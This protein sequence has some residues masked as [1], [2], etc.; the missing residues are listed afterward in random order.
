MRY[1][2]LFRESFDKL[3]IEST[4]EDI[5]QYIQIV[6]DDL[7]LEKIDNDDL[8]ILVDGYEFDYDEPVLKWVKTIKHISPARWGGEYYADND[9][10]TESKNDRPQ[11]RLIIGRSFNDKEETKVE[12]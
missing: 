12:I 10:L 8:E 3:N 2:K 6:I 7:N 11:I 4:I 9:C 5:K 1:I